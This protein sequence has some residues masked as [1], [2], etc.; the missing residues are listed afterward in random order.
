MFDLPLMLA[1][2]GVVEPVTSFYDL[3]LRNGLLGGAVA[4]LIW[5]LIKRDSQ[6][7]EAQAARLADAKVFAELVKNAT[8][9]MTARTSADDER[10]RAL[11]IAA[12]AAEKS[13]IVI[14]QMS[15]E[16]QSL[17]SIIKNK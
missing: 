16:I 14:D 10:N 4:L 6:L 3:L 5:L 9:A 12:R 11:E 7:Q 13:A 17:N 8:V 15:K 2:A 1:D